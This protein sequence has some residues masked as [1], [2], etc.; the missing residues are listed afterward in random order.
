[1]RRSALLLAAAAA[2]AACSGHRGP[3]VL[4][5]RI[6]P[7]VVAE[8]G[9]MELFPVCAEIRQVCGWEMLPSDSTRGGATLENARESGTA[10]EFLDGLV[11]RHPVY[12]WFMISDVLNVA[13]REVGA[14]NPL[15]RQ[16][17]VDARRLPARQV[18]RELVESAGLKLVGEGRSE[19]GYYS[20][21]PGRVDLKVQGLRLRM[22][23]NRLVAA[24]G[25]TGWWCAPTRDPDSLRCGLVSWRSSR[26]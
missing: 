4:E 5:Q 22:A 2:A 18:L 3:K 15:D 21:E 1:M 10:R 17:W 12:R 13:P 25:A 14:N 8:T 16:A 24:E 9:P 6:T 7:P 26:D 11:R 23:L 20:G 19:L